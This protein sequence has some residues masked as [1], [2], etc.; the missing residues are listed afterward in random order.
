MHPLR[1]LRGYLPRRGA[2]AMGICLQDKF[3]EQQ[4]V[5][6]APETMMAF[7]LSRR[8]TKA[9]RRK[10]VPGEV[11]EQLIEVGTHAGTASNS[12]TRIS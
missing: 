6:I 9:F 12:Q 10:A 3:E 2:L 1:P 7:L 11:I 8:S 5:V 4:R